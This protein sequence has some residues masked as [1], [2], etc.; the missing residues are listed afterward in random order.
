MFLQYSKTGK[1]TNRGRLAYQLPPSGLQLKFFATAF[2][3]LVRHL[4]PTKAR[5]NETFTRKAFP[6]YCTN[7]AGLDISGQ[8][9]QSVGFSQLY[10]L[11]LVIWL[12]AYRVISCDCLYS[13]RGGRS[14]HEKLS[15]RQKIISCFVNCI[16]YWIRIIPVLALL[17]RYVYAETTFYCGTFLIKYLFTK[18]KSAFPI[19][20]N[21]AWPY[22]LGGGDKVPEWLLAG[23]QPWV[24]HY[25]A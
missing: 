20:W 9:A 16:C 23:V 22:T 13:R 19:K 3:T 2:V 25:S 1:I 11:D 24:M 15:T 4:T 21:I 14:T 8:S 5:R 18:N 6:K 7:N 12:I 17:I 10:W